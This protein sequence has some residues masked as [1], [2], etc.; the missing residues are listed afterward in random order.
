L[1]EPD[2]PRRAEPPQ[3]ARIST[4]RFLVLL[5]AI[6]TGAIVRSAIATRL[7]DFT[8]DEPYHI[9]AGVSYIR[10]GD[11]RINPEHPPLVKLWVGSALA[12]TGFRLSP[13][14][15]F[16]DKPDERAFT[17][18]NVFLQNDGDSVQRRSRRAMWALNG[19]L[20]V[21]LALALRRC[22]GSGV[23]LGTTLVLAIDPTVA[24][25]L[26]VVM[27]DL[28]VALLSA[29][30]V[31]LATRAFR[32]WNWGDLAW[33]SAALGLA[34]GTKHSAPVFTIFLG[35]AGCALALFAPV[36][37]PQD[38]GLRRLGKVACVLLGALTILWACYGFRFAESRA[39]KEVFNRPLAAKIA[40][41][42]SRGYRFV[43]RQMAATHLVPRAYI[44]GFADTV[45]A[46]LEGR[47]FQQL[48]FGRLYYAKAPWY[49]FPGVIAAKL[50]IGIS[51]LVGLGIFLFF[52]RR[53]PREWN[54]P[55]TLLIAA[56]LLFLFIL[57][58]GATYAGVRHALP[59]VLFLA[60]FAGMA[61]HAALAASGKAL[62]VVA[63]LAFLAAALSALPVM[64]PWEYY[65]EIVG[66]ARK[67]PLYF[68][69]E[70]IDVSQ[71]S[72][73]LTAYYYQ[74]VRPTG[75]VPYVSYNMFL[76]E[77]KARGVDWLGRDLPRDEERMKSGTFTGTIMTSARSLTKHLWW[78][79]PAVRAAAPVA[80]FGNLL[81]F[82]GTFDVRG[83]LAR[84]L[85]AL[86]IRKEYSAEKPDLDAAERLLKE[87]AEADPSPFFVH[88]ELGNIYLQRASRE[89]ALGAYN[90]ALKYA[91]PDD[92]IRR[93]IEEQIR[94]VTTEPLPQISPLRNPALE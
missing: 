24:A 68:D 5:S 36:A 93:P 67:A 71:R 60:I 72:K 86:G 55:A 1:S 58:S 23:A 21:L 70:G 65:N 94:R 79:L 84:N 10:H 9:T 45:R 56:M 49:F 25:H 75:E 35:L 43:L 34:L 20:L 42:N 69:D 54:L 13:L 8:L 28:P 44:W 73:E 63:G 17:E 50:P 80:R 26:P 48:A 89:E 4:R 29:T 57:S 59:A 39:A 40:D 76:Q 87:S 82:Q 74:S 62:K 19:L 90:A 33:C 3:P 92:V 14:R 51:F 12:A 78:D 77:R 7:D 15:E 83:R 30:A 53:F 32:S 91:P 6:V 61:S 46:G 47:A 31:V 27:T 52:G 81:V 22:F 88:L 2:E 41:V 37:E 38:S 18:D 64:R 11:F 66:G 85:Y 16:R